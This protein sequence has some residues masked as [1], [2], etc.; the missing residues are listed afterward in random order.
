[1]ASHEVV[2]KN[3]GLMAILIVIVVSIGG[4]VEIVPLFFSASTTEPAEGIE[5]YGALELAGRDIYVREGCYNCHSQMIRPFRAETE[6]YGHYSVAGEFVYDRPFQWGSKR[7]GPDL[8]RIGER[9][10]DEWHRAHLMNPRDVVPQSN[11]PAF[12]WLADN[13]VDPETVVTRMRVQK[14]W[15]NVP[16]T[17]AQLDEATAKLEG[18]T[19]MQAL[20]AYLQHLG[21]DFSAQEK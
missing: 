20:I 16:Y 1:M 12:P 3:I 2:E 11:M 13:E 10:S 9:Y 6:R 19:E 21:T 15:L 17:D 18:K 7:T 8:A 4:L 5:P 14:D